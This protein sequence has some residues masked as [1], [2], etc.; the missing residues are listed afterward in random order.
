MVLHVPLAHLAVAG[1]QY[2]LQHSFDFAQVSPTA[3][4][5]LGTV[6]R[7]FP[8]TYMSQWPEQHSLFSRQS[9]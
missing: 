7:N 8:S 9:V 2:R 1:S 5:E 4:Q 6:Q 3:L